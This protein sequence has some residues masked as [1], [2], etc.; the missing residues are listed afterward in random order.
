MPNTAPQLINPTLLRTN[1]WM[2]SL[3]FHRS[4][5]FSFTP[6]HIEDEEEIESY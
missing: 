5:M 1:T 6:Y 4:V 3:L 2:S